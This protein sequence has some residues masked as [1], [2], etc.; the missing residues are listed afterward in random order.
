MILDAVRSFARTLSAVEGFLK[1]IQQ[2]AN[3]AKYPE[4]THAV[5]VNR[6]AEEK[7]LASLVFCSRWRTN[8]YNFALT[9]ALPRTGYGYDYYRI[10]L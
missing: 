5:N 9:P 7:Y 10:G 2:P 6:T 8:L 3:R 4:R 1:G